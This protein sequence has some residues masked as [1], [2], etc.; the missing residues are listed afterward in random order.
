MVQE[1]N[2]YQYKGEVK[3]KYPSLGRLLIA[4]EVARGAVDLRLIDEYDDIRHYRGD[5]LLIVDSKYKLHTSPRFNDSVGLE[6]YSLIFEDVTLRRLLDS[7]SV[8]QHNGRK[9]FI[10]LYDH[11]TLGEFHPKEIRLIGRENG[12]WNIYI[13]DPK[14]H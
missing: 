3:V 13:P 8:E 6:G 9:A 10:G 4:E 14:T 12:N 11:L 1:L 5:N 7:D 2:G